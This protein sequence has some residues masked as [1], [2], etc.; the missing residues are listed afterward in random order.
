MPENF[1]RTH[2][3]GVPLHP[4]TQMTAYGLRSLAL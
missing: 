2:L 3:D 1:R 4:Q